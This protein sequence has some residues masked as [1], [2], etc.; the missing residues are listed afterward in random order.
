MRT[1]KWNDGAWIGRLRAEGDPLAD[2]CVRTLYELDTS[3]GDDRA[4]DLVFERMRANDDQ[5]PDNAPPVLKAFFAETGKLPPGADGEESLARFGR[6]ARVFLTNGLLTALVLLAKSI[7]SGYGAPCLTKILEIS[8]NLDKK[9][10]RRLLGVLQMVV[11]VAS[12][13]AFKPGGKAIL[14]AQKLRLLH[15]GVRLIARRDERLTDYERRYGVPVNHEDMLAT[16]MGFSYLV[17]TGFRT[18]KVGLTPEQEEDY[19][20]L[21][22]VFAQLMAIPAECVPESVAEAGAFY[23]AYARR[24]FAPLEQNP[25]G[26]HLADRNL[27]MLK[28]MIPQWLRR[29]GLGAVP[30]IYMCVLLSPEECARVRI[31]PAIGHEAL[32]ALLLELP[33]LW[34]E[35]WR[36]V[37]ARDLSAHETLSRLFFQGLI[38]ESYGGEVRFRIPLDLQELRELPER[39]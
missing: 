6:G 17:I 24:Q 7:P 19:Y 39:R 32:R 38:D 1:D 34:I 14:T 5:V 27:K 29:L 33:R 25:F 16:I 21:W 22:R 18:L 8:E 4:T 15:A 30:R 37:D 23:D 31:K 36:R 10:Y 20:Y 11:N 2:A 12:P 35:L 9:T 13:G 26:A 28:L 3:P